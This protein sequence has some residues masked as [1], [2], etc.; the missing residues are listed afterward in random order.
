MM[1]L[2]EEIQV[3]IFLRLPVNSI[4]ACRCVC[5]PLRVLLSKP[6]F[7]KSHLNRSIQ[8]SNPR[9]MVDHFRH[10]E[11]SKNRTLHSID[12][13]S[14]SSL[15]LTSTQQSVFDCGGAV[16]MNF[17][18]EAEASLAWT[19]KREKAETIV[20]DIWGSCNGLICL[21]IRMSP[22][23]KEEEDIVCIWNPATKEYKKISL[24]ICDGYYSIRYGFG[25]DNSIDNYQLVSVTDYEYAGSFEIKVYTLGSDSWSTIRTPVPYSF[26]VDITHG[27]LFKGALHWLGTTTDQKSSA[28]VIVSFDV[29][30]KRLLGLSFPERSLVRTMNYPIHR[31]VCKNVAVLRDHLC[32]AFI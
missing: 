4:L 17:P 6:E 31:R 3:N 28:E 26:P 30:S 21:G 14:M 23:T 22:E 5:K 32:L 11:P 9:L 19:K 18:F 15:S 27:L 8:K 13:E 1:I 20:V 16:V 29:S 25:Y 24:P 12:Y 10:Q 2:P 7:I